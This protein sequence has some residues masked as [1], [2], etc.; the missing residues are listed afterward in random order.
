[1]ALPLA[2]SSTGAASACDGT[3]GCRAHVRQFEKRHPDREAY[4]MSRLRLTGGISDPSTDAMQ[5]IQKVSQGHVC[6]ILLGG[7]GLGLGLLDRVV[8]L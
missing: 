1:L 2:F 4:L 8:R 6:A 3:L 7:L 5:K